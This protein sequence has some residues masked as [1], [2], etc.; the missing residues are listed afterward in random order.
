[1]CTPAVTSPH[2]CTHIQSSKF[3]LS[4]RTELT[5]NNSPLTGLHTFA[6]YSE[7]GWE[8]HRLRIPVCTFTVCL[9]SNHKWPTW[10][11]FPE[12]VAPTTST[13]LFSLM[14]LMISCLC[15]CTGRE[16]RKASCSEE[17]LCGGTTGMPLFSRPLAL[18]LSKAFSERRTLLNKENTSYSSAGVMTETHQP[19]TPKKPHFWCWAACPHVPYY[20]WET[21]PAGCGWQ[22]MYY[23]KDWG[24]CCAEVCLDHP[25]L[26]Q[27][28]SD[29]V[30]SWKA[31]ICPV[32][33][34]QRTVCLNSSE[35]DWVFKSSFFL[36]TCEIYN[37]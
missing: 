26:W 30:P 34:T 12:P 7:G 32:L 14:S 23:G 17:L 15:S 2:C 11:V 29:L 25:S 1:M 19:L 35:T 33:L 31:E 5:G 3:K 4:P 10:V 20:W 18:F 21:V 8:S 37:P 16:H 28:G 9:R 6:I 27:W 22:I 36:Q 24:A 13:T